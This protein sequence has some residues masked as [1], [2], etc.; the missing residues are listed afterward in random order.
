MQNG[1]A[2]IYF[3]EGQAVAKENDEKL[4]SAIGVIVKAHAQIGE[5]IKGWD[6]VPVESKEFCYEKLAVSKN[7]SLR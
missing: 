5:K 2:K 1:R 6:T 4:S 3:P 7:I